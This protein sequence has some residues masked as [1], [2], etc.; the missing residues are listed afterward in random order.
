MENR[1][2]TFIVGQ[3]IYNHTDKTSVL[4]LYSDFQVFLAILFIC[5]YFF[6][7]SYV[8][9]LSLFL[10]LLFMFTIICRHDTLRSPK[11]TPQIGCH[12]QTSPFME[13]LLFSKISS[14]SQ[15]TFYP[16]LF[17]FSVLSQCA[18]CNNF[19]NRSRAHFHVNNCRRK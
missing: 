15:S 2:P 5:Y 19:N 14:S 17:L 10:L 1:T 7:V 6:F 16:H 11:H 4:S 3:I 12:F 18:Y 9:I 13:V 8:F